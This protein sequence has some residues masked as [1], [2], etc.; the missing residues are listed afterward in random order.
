MKKIITIMTICFLSFLLFFYSL[1]GNAQVNLVPNPSFEVYD[2]CPN[3]LNQVNRAIG[4]ISSLTPDY[5]NSCALSNLCS[6]PNNLFG[7]H[8]AAS[9]NAYAG[10]YANIYFPQ[11]YREHAGIHLI[12]DLQ[13]GSKYYISIKV[14]LSP[15][16]NATEYCGINKLG[17]LFSSVQYDDFNPAPVNNFAHVYTNTIITDTLN[18]V[19]IRGS[20]VA[21]SAYSFL[22]IGNFF[23]DALTDSIQI[24]GSQCNAYYFLDDICVSTDSSYT[25]NYTY[26]GIVENNKLIDISIHPNPA[27][28]YIDIDFTSL[29]EPYNITIYDVLGR[30]VM[31]ACC[32]WIIFI[33]FNKPLKRM[34][35]SKSHLHK[36]K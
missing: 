1:E 10:F 23:K 35:H 31:R 18:W 25:Y 16:G 7:N 17:V 22:S 30:E 9:G 13:I 27:M 28:N 8:F 5:F 20:F 32:S 2:S 15:A 26:T 34:A 11:N 12:S 29:D 14:S 33:P 6:V 21:D 36:C 3:S 24:A 4:W 19:S